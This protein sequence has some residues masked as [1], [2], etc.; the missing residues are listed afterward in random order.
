MLSALNQ[1][2][3]KYR[4]KLNF[5]PPSIVLTILRNIQLKH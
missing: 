2:E 1:Q 4:F 3:T 5:K